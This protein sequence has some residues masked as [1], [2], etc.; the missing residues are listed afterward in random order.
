MRYLFYLSLF[1][2]VSLKS[3][4]QELVL[5]DR[6]LTFDNRPVGDSNTITIT[7]EELLKIKE[8]RT[9]Y[10]WAK[11]ESFTVFAGTLGS[12]CTSLVNCGS[13][14]VCSDLKI[15]FKSSSKNDF[16][17]FDPIVTNRMGVRIPWQE[18]CVKIK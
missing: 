10:S 5:K 3:L 11:I 6:K 17:C 14:T 4:S 8:L 2:I 13:D 12:H 9:N 1:L 15:L 18:L 7:K 16:F